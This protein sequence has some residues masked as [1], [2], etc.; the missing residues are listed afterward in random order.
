MSRVIEEFQSWRWQIEKG[1]LYATEAFKVAK[2][3]Y[4]CPLRIKTF[5]TGND[6]KFQGCDDSCFSVGIKSNYE[7]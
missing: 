3:R 2:A 4:E 5:I 1:K 7:T 6:V